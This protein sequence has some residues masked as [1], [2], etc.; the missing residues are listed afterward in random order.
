MLTFFKYKEFLRFRNTHY[1]KIHKG[2]PLWCSGIGGISRRLGLGPIPAPAQQ[3]KD[4][5]FSQ[6]RLRSDPWPKNSLFLRVAKKEKGKT[7]QNKQKKKNVKLG[8]VN[9]AERHK[10]EMRASHHL[11][12][13]YLEHFVVISP[14]G[15]NACIYASCVFLFLCM[16]K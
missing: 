14:G 4:P 2:I 9:N 3:I 6:L 12:A 8:Y 10:S 16:Y 11:K 5:V 15:C 1:S 13:S 7:K